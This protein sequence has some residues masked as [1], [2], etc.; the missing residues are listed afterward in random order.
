MIAFTLCSNNYLPKARILGESILQH[1]PHVR[2]IIGLVDQPDGQIDYKALGPFEILPIKEVG[3]P[4]FD[5]MVLRYDLVDLNTAAKPF[6]FRYL[7]GRHDAEKDLKICYFDPD[8]CAYAALRPIEEGLD[9]SAFLL[10]PHVLSPIAS[11]GKSP[12]EQT[13]LTFGLY[14]LGFCAARRSEVADRLLDWWSDHLVEDCRYDAANGLFV[15]QA[16]MD[17]AP[18]FFESVEIT[19][20]PGLNLAYWNLH[21][22]QLDFRNGAWQVNNQWPLVFYHFSNLAP[23]GS[24]AITKAPTRFTLCDR[25]ELQPLFREYRSKLAAY[26][27]ERFRSV[28]CAYV[29]KRTEWLKR[30]RQLY[31]RKHPFRLLTSG[32]KRAVPKRLKNFVRAS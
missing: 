30:E 10:T 3:I 24:E 28:P 16:W 26:D 2:F 6:Y 25:P 4:N 29:V 15:D 1:N 21:E 17:L 5:E 18:I 20:H 8:I 14:N 13:F 19:R 31:Y 32:F 7:F 12:K 27:M 22:R 11:D 9:R 23:N